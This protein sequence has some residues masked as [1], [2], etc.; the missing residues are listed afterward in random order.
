MVER[1]AIAF[2]N[3]HGL[4]GLPFAI[5]G[6]VYD[7]RQVTAAD[8][9]ADICRQVSE[10]TNE[11][12]VLIVIDTVSRAL[13]GGDENSPKDMG[14]LVMTSGMVQQKC[15]TAHVLWVHHIPHDSDRLRGHGAL[16][17]AVDTSVSVSAGGTAR[18]AKV[19]KANDA[20]EGESVSF[21]I[22]SVTIHEDGTTAPIP[23]VPADQVT[24]TAATICHVSFRLEQR[25]A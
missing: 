16:L 20:E 13:A 25:S 5:V 2:R 19:V 18:T 7:F 21:T 4:Q 15:P 14:A 1:R 12:V 11:D 3:K 10:V 24:G 17:G 9:I 23:A 8:A 22:E 6:G